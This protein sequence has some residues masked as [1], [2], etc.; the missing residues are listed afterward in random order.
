M[1][2]LCGSRIQA[3]PLSCPYVVMTEP[4]LK[5]F[6]SEIVSIVAAYLDT[7]TLRKIT[8]RFEAQSWTIYDNARE[9]FFRLRHV[10]VTGY[11]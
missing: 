9:G 2:H 5:L 1:P 4:D 7:V 8:D 3:L 11:P 10:W 6:V